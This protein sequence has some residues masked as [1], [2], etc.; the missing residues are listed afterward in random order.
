MIGIANNLTKATIL[1][2][3]VLSVEISVKNKG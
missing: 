3:A 1:K 2:Q